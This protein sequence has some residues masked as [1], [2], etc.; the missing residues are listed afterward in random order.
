MWS[1]VYQN[2]SFEYSYICSYNSLT[3]WFFSHENVG[4][5]YIAHETAICHNPHNSANHDSRITRQWVTTAL[6]VK[7]LCPKKKFVLIFK[8]IFCLSLYLKKNVALNA[9]Q[10]MIYQVFSVCIKF[11]ISEL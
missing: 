8:Q 11:C 5:I 6:S 7:I 10:L 9:G 2:T 3:A 1:F 4:H